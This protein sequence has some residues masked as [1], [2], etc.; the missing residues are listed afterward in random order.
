MAEAIDANWPG[1]DCSGLS[2]Q[3]EEKRS[4]RVLIPGAA[5]A[6]RLCVLY[7]LCDLKLDLQHAR[8]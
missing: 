7:V 8:R 1:G 6:L 5:L 2:P 3:A 4:Q